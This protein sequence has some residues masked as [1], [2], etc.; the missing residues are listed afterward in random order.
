MTVTEQAFDTSA[1]ALFAI[2][3]EPDTYPEWLVGTKTIR[4][5]SADWPEPESFFKHAVGF[6]P[7]AIPDTTTARAVAAPTML[8][9]LVRARPLI[10][11]VVR[12]DISP[13]SSG[14]V[15]R[16]TET[17]VGIFKLVAPVAQPLIRLRNERS[18]HRLK[19]LVER[20]TGS[21]ST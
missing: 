20:G 3:V 11:A 15:L 10:E 21:S 5:V 14:C 17:P 19:A 7:V 12:F 16:M 4:E 9:L 2:I 8:E 6:G 13:T 1:D 18:L